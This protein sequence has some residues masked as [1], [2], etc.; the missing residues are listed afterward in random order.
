VFTVEELDVM[1]EYAVVSRNSHF[2]DNAASGLVSVV[3]PT[4]GPMTHQHD[5]FFRYQPKPQS[6]IRLIGCRIKT[7]PQVEGI[8]RHLAAET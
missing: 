2:A 1:L 8:S 7:Q 6:M 3:P 4:E 5:S